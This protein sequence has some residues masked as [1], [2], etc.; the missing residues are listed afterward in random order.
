MTL[1]VLV[2][3]DHPSVRAGLIAALQLEPD[4]DVVGEAEDGPEAIERAAALAPD[5]VVLDYK[6][7]RLDGTEAANRI[8]AQSPKTKV[9]LLTGHDDP[10]LLRTALKTGATGFILKSATV[11]E[12]VAAVRTVARGDT[13]VDPRM[14]RHLV[15]GLTP[16]P[17]GSGPRALS[18]REA[19]VLRLSASGLVMKEIA[20]KMSLGAR[21]IETYKARGMEKLGL[22]SRAALM[23][24]ALSHDWLTRL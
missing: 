13:Y 7:P 19:E 21:T 16:L 23:V 4:L 6:L 18:E 24:Y 17:S 14:V 20:A 2:C 11:E 9:L 3:D 12:V 5:V 15:S 10:A 8:L 22:T 1:H